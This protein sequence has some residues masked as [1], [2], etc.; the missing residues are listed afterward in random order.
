MKF[1]NFEKAYFK[2]RKYLSRESQ[3]RRFVLETIKWSSKVGKSNFLD[4]TEKTALVVGCGCGFETDLL[5]KLGYEV[6]GL[7]ISKFG[8]KY[9]KYRFNSP[10]FIISDVQNGLPF[11]SDFF[12]LVICTEVL[13]HLNYPLKTLSEILRIGKDAVVCTSPNRK[14][15][16]LIKKIFRDLDETHINSKTKKEWENLIRENL[17][18][19]FLKIESFMDSCPRINDKLLFYKSFRLPYFGLSL[20]IFFR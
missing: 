4:G 3:I 18:P 2:K 5:S 11:K 7:D 20:R 6:Y 12:D 13:E 10:E 1:M 17:K 16:K 14:V 19:N 9:A 8:I 15:E